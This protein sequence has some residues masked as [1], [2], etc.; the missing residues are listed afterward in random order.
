MVSDLYLATWPILAA[1]LGT[2]NPLPPLHAP[3]DEHAGAADAPA[4]PEA[5]RENMRRGRLQSCLPYTLQDGYGRDLH[6]SALRTAVLENEL[7]R[8][9][10]LLDFGGRLWSLYHKQAQRELLHANPVLQPAN[11][12][13]RNAWFA[14]GVEWNI[15]IIG[16]SP[17]TCAPP[18]AAR[19]ATSDGTP[20]LRLYEW[21]RL[22]QVPYQIDAYLPDGS[23]VLFV[24]VRISNPHDRA[25]P[26]YW[27]SNMAVPQSQETRVVVPATAKAKAPPA[28]DVPSAGALGR[29]APAGSACYHSPAR[30]R[31]GIDSRKFT[32]RN[33][34]RQE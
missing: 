3:R 15:G 6:P 4:L 29:V 31:I 18:Y 12:A 33:H 34:I 13:V 27:W 22:R 23:P 11:L 5:M 9:S 32:R 1:D 2:E 7:L 16:H 24:R 21:E 8:A 19:L 25:I 26:M 20:V 30:R 10:F 28:H 17:H 14:G